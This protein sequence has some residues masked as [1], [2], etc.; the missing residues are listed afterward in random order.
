[1]TESYYKFDLS[2]LS[3]HELSIL[4]R[5]P[6]TLEFLPILDKATHIDLLNEPVENL[7][8]I[9]AEVEDAVKKFMDYENTISMYERSLQRYL[10]GGG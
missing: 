6:K 1:M 2:K 7:P 5:E 10:E 9:G 8:R 3:L 4:G